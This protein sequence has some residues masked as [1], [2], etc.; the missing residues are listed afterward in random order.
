MR[1]KLQAVPAGALLVAVMTAPLAAQETKRDTLFRRLLDMPGM[2]KG[3]SVQ[4]R[5]MADSA[6]FW[7]I[8]SAPD[9]TVA[10]V[11]DPRANTVA[12]LLDVARVRQSLR[13]AIGHEPPYAGLPF[14]N[15][16]FANGEKSVRFSLEGRDWILDRDTY[17]VRAVP[18]VSA[19][20]RARV[21]PQLVRR[22]FPATGPDLYELPS[23]DRRWFAGEL[24]G[25]LVLR[26]SIDG[27]TEQL[28]RDGTPDNG[29]SVAASRWSPNS[30]YL[31]TVNYDNRKLHRVP[32]LHW[33][34]PL[35]E[36]EWYPFTKVG[37]PLP[38][39]EPSII[40]VLGRRV[41]RVAPGDSA[42]SRVFPVAWL[43][44]G[45][46][47]FFYRITRDMRRLEVLG[48][49][50]ATGQTRVVHTETQ[51][52]FIKGIA[53]NP[54]WT[55]LFT[56]LDDG[57]RYLFISER[58]GWDHIYLYS[59][60]GTLIRRL[61]EGAWPVLQIVATDTRGGWVYFTGHAESR[62]YDTHL[63]RVGLD[64]RGF[65]R[66]TEG[67][68]THSAQ[69]S[70]SKAYFIDTHSNVD[71]PPTAEL[72]STDGKLIRVLS[73]GTIDSLL[74]LGWKAP[75]EFVVKAA[76]GTTDLHGVL[77]KPFDFD[78]SR[79]YPIIEYIYGGP[80]TVNAP[81]AFTQS[82]VRE[83]AFAQLGFI[84]LVLDARGTP[85]RGKAFQD[86]VYRNFGRNEIPDHAAALKQL[87]TARP[88]M[89]LSR[90]GIYGGS[91]GGYMT[92]RALVL[93]PETYH[94]GVATYPVAEMYDHATGAI[95]GYMDLVER[96][97][98]GYDY[99]SSLRLIG[100]LKG[101]LM[102]IH[103][104]SDVNATF[105]ATMKVVDALTKANKQ[106][107]LRVFP[108]VNHGLAGIYDYWIESTRLF[109]VRHLNP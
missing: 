9:R 76:D 41:I 30:L 7:Y 84:T 1:P 25:N 38:V 106:Y 63:Y 4:A 87:G 8:D 88:Y 100:N 29:W 85:E 24:E 108:E 98:A 17:Q 50:V 80:Q 2:V 18:A 12:P 16:S 20:D 14:A 28:T 59:I 96:N 21:E 32:L 36:V 23:P 48:T 93:A 95:E 10:L 51:P 61:T 65:Q 3:G 5:W 104:T 89:D 109:F 79:K 71:R 49:T 11:V 66:L 33:L 53:S 43:P 81:H 40:D 97:R 91:W 42:G 22:A 67:T 13:T 35:E 57:K 82:W 44:D 55:S 58:D 107:D 77:F 39:L 75:E 78:P 54:G 74:A 31:A 37:G 62:P 46:E 90:V 72:R 64:G 69:F 60:D 83:Q 99:G 52:T 47:A 34:K 27:R 19:A 26:A 45:S 68:G 86:V 56:L 103:G 94:A 102:L 70:P 105:S 15:F 73:K 92:I 6:S 101:N